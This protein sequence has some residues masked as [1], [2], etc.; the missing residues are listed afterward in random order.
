MKHTNWLAIGVG[1]TALLLLLDGG[2][3]IYL[4]YGLI[5]ALSAPEYNELAKTSQPIA[6]QIELAKSIRPL[7]FSVIAQGI[8]LGTFGLVVVVG[9]LHHRRWAPRLLLLGSF[10][11]ALSSTAVIA[12]GP[13]LWDQQGIYILFSSIY[14][15]SLHVQH[16]TT[17]R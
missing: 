8:V 10:A 11:L 17:A 2:F 6:E 1:V 15:W 4:A 13:H 7:M 3:T 16:S 12:L 5:D 14:W 9:L